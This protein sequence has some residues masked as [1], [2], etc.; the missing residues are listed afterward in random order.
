MDQL[1]KC[2]SFFSIMN[3]MACYNENNSR[4]K[5]MTYQELLTHLFSISD[6]KFASFSKSIS[7]SSY[8]VIG[9]KNPALR[10]IIKEHKNDVELLTDD[11]VL[12]KYLEVDF[13]YFGL[14]LSREKNIN[15]Q[16]KFLKEKIHLAKSW[17]ITDCS[18][19]F[20]KKT[21][22]D[23]FYDFFIDMYQRKNIYERRM[24]YV[25]ALKQYKDERIKEILPLIK[26]KEE[27][28][29][30]MAEAWLLSV[31]ALTYEDDVFDYLAKTDDLVLMRKTI[32]KICDSY[33]FDEKSK[34]RFKE[35][36]TKNKKK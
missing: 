36:R 14:S 12:G 6:K 35:L 27:Y 31:I 1:T 28:M 20:L 29:V 3:N 25:L 13:I 4:K 32:S 17:I 9:V 19:S 10:A 7:N 22:F 30:Y 18:S 26:T 33:R 5:E 23:A 11:F 16:L 2:Q 24:A 34:N 8:E 21:S 15:S